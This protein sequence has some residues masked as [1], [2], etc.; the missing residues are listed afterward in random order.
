MILSSRQGGLG[1]ARMQIPNWDKEA[2]RLH[3]SIKGLGT[4]ELCIVRIL[5]RFTH[6]ERKKLL[7]AYKERFNNVRENGVITLCLDP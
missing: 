3:D 6:K 5:S 7:K 2:D 1:T 4:D